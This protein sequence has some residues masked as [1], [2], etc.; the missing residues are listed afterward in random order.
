[1]N[2]EHLENLLQVYYHQYV[3]VSHWKLDLLLNI[4]PLYNLALLLPPVL[5][6]K[7]KN[8]RMLHQRVKICFSFIFLMSAS[9]SLMI[10][11]I[12]IYRERNAS[13]LWPLI[14]WPG[15]VPVWEAPLQNLLLLLPARH[16]EVQLLHHRQQG[17]DQRGARDSRLHCRGDGGHCL[18]STRVSV[19]N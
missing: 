1:M 12:I 3:A 2:V 7:W 19:Q 8:L 4:A 10:W 9:L 14:Y 11:I 17:G 6:S 15:P 5:R 18:L 13:E 16:H